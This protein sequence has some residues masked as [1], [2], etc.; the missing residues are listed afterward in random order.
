MK[1]LFLFISFAIFIICFGANAQ[2]IVLSDGNVGINKSTPTHKLDIDGGGMRIIY[3]SNKP[4][5]IETWNSGPRICSDSKIIFYK[6]SGGGYIDVHCKVLTEYSDLKAKDG[7]TSI[8][9]TALEKIKSLNGY[10]YHWKDDPVKKKH[11]GLIAQD[12]ELVIPEAVFTSDSVDSKSIAYSAIIPYLVEAIKEQQVHINKM[13]DQIKNKDNLK[14]A[15]IDGDGQ[16]E[17]ELSDETASLYQNAPNPFSSQTTISFMIPK[18]VNTAQLHI[19][20]M[21][22]N[23]LKTISINERGS[24]SVQINGNEFNAGMYFYS[25]VNDG[26]IIDTKQMLLTN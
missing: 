23:L 13:E 7:L 14:S 9:G 12:V 3:S 20:N 19:C 1:K 10:K 24:G 16:N 18:S 8:S 25:L 26:K 15:S 5:S 4:Y 11:A 17:F 21:V 6:P 22:G 2:L